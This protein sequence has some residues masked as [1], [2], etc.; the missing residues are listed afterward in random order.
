MKQLVLVAVVVACGSEPPARSPEQRAD[1]SAAAV[2]A[3]QAARFSEAERTATTALELDPRNARAAAVRAIARYQAAGEQLY[4]EIEAA[5]QKGDKLGFLDH[6]QGRGAWRSFGDALDAIDR[7][8]AIAAADPQFSL[9][10]CMACWEHDWNH[11]GRIDDRDRMLFEIEFDGHGGSLADGDPRRRPTFR[12][13]V[14]DVDWARAMIAF[15]HAAIELVL[16]YRWT[17]LDKLFAFGRSRDDSRVVIHLDDADRVKHARSLVLAGLAFA[18]RSRA[19][20]L[21]ETDDDR[22]WVPNPR[23]KNHPMP[24]EVDDPLFETWA[25]VTGDVRRMLESKDGISMREA[26]GL[27]DRKLAFLVPDAYVDL[28]AMFEHPSDIV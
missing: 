3:L 1:D 7:D 17:E 27:V 2:S 9:E 16:G 12:F 22:E 8:L 18:D 25:G 11:N 15:Q 20:Y 19:E 6:A 14:G 13:D 5:L 24:L 10:L 4:G 23:Q 26:A 21:A 28:G